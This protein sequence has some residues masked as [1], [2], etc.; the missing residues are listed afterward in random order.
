M[1]L[2]AL[3]A[4]LFA[5]GTML[6]GQTGDKTGP[7]IGSQVPDFEAPDQNGARHSLGSLMGPQGLM[8]VFF[9]SADW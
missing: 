7:A 2:F 5:G 8:L 3:S 6:I 4:F 1:R 9:R